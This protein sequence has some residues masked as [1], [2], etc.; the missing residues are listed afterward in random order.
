V[1]PVAV[2]GL[3][4]RE[5]PVPAETPSLALARE[6]EPVPRAG[7]VGPMAASNAAVA[8]LEGRLQMELPVAAVLPRGAG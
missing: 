8:G 7:L 5:L 1:A 3:A 2:A 4:K 6:A